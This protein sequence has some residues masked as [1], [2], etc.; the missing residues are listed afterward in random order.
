MPAEKG[1]KHL[2]VRPKQTGP[3]KGQMLW[4]IKLRILEA[5]RNGITTVN[6]YRLRIGNSGMESISVT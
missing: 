1:G 2:P 5:K 3:P 6:N 4:K